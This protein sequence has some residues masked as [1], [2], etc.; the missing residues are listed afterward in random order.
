MN[1]L[2]MIYEYGIQQY[3][4]MSKLE[5]SVTHDG[6]RVGHFECVAG[7]VVGVVV[8][9]GYFCKAIKHTVTSGCYHDHISQFLHFYLPD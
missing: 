2:K 1:Y 6:V 5:L 8:V 4:L 7:P 3:S 9:G